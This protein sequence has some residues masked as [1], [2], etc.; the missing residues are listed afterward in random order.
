MA[1]AP[2]KGTAGNRTGSSARSSIRA[3]QSRGCSVNSIARS[4]GRD[5]STI[6][7]IASGAIKNP[8]R[9]LASNVRKCKAKKKS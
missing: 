5:S 7:K 2:K 8:P 1:K 3:A 4:T 9:N 6:S